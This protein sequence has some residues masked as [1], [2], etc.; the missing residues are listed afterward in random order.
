MI[1]VFYLTPQLCDDNGYDHD[2]V[3]SWGY[4]LNLSL[5]HI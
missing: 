1:P 5:I 4:V 2:D 3:G